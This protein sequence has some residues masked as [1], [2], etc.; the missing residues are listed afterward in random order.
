MKKICMLL[1]AAIVLGVFGQAF[2]HPHHHDHEE[3][4]VI[5][6]AARRNIKLLTQAEA[7]NIAEKRIGKGKITFHDVELEDE[8][9][10][11]PNTERFRPVYKIE[12]YSGRDEY[13]IEIDA[14]TGEILKFKL[15]D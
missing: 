9:D 15:D 14:I 2:S 10:D 6:E 1:A 5:E 13:D 8:H 7:R 11:Y 3:Q 4:Y 12:C